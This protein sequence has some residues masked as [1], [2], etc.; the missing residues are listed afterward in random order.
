MAP[1]ARRVGHEPTLTPAFFISLQESSPITIILE[2]DPFD[3]YLLRNGGSPLNSTSTATNLHIVPTWCRNNS[4]PASRRETGNAADFQHPL[5]RLLD[6]MRPGW[7]MKDRTINKGT[8]ERPLGSRLG[9]TFVWTY[10]HFA[11]FLAF[12]HQSS[13]FACKH[14]FIGEAFCLTLPIVRPWLANTNLI[15]AP[16]SPCTTSE[17]FENGT[18]S[19]GHSAFV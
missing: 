18:T 19:T 7:C 15:S 12:L 16:S 4:R 8:R 10:T 1:S 6:N 17:A 11:P 5:S 14:H 9:W 2:S 13:F 3:S